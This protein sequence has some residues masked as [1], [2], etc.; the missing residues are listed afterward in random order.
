MLPL[1]T[2]GG[3]QDAPVGE[4]RTHAMRHRPSTANC[5]L[6]E[7]VE[8]LQTRFL[9]QDLLVLTERQARNDRSALGPPDEHHG[10]DQKGND[11]DHV[12]RDGHRQIVRPRASGVII[13]V[14]PADLWSRWLESGTSP[15]A[16]W[17]VQDDRD[18]PE[19]RLQEG[20][21]ERNEGAKTDGSRS[22]DQRAPARTARHPTLHTDTGPDCRDCIPGYQHI[23]DRCEYRRRGA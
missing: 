2:A 19:N 14:L 17:P 1:G 9:E 10:D 21:A 11:N 12:E 13:F 22:D 20:P 23:D 18:N 3:E 16:S 5:R 7:P 6:T 4:D 8:E 15:P